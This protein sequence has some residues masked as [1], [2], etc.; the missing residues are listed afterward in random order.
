MY[1]LI[2]IPLNNELFISAH[3]EN[4]TFAPY[5]SYNQNI[6]GSLLHGAI[7]QSFHNVKQLKCDMLQ[8]SLW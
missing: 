7:A 8:G 1:G 2:S 5:V 4:S 6:E 3:N